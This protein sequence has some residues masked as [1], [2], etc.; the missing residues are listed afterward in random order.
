VN[1]F[2]FAIDSPVVADVAIAACIGQRNSDGIFMNIKTNKNAILFH[3]LPPWLWL[4]VVVVKY[5]H[6]PRLQGAG[7]LFFDDSH[8][9]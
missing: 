3:D 2:K 1:G 4:C 6:N 8:Y 9:V 7:H 5:Q